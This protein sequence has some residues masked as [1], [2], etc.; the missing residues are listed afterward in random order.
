MERIIQ[1]DNLL[2][3]LI[4]LG[5]LAG[6]LGFGYIAGKMS[7]RIILVGLA[8]I[9][10]LIAVLTISTWFNYFPFIL[11]IM[12]AIS[13]LALDTGTQTTI[14]D[15][16]VF[17]AAIV[18]ILIL[19]QIF[20]KKPDPINLTKEE[21]FLVIFLMIVPV[22]LIWS[23]L[24]KDQGLTYDFGFVIVQIAT[25]FTM[26]LLPLVIAGNQENRYQ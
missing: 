18:G 16:M 20:G 17:S 13:P 8:G 15:G 19:N 11:L 1:R 12:A 3:V 7:L 25:A 14:S 9:G 10:G 21:R 5:V 23:W 2:K 26:I 22:S 4:L 24:F 6:S